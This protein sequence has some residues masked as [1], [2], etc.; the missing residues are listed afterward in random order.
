M[1]SDFILS[2]S[3]REH[4]A[5]SAPAGKP[6]PDEIATLTL[7]LRR[8]AEAP[9]EHKA[10]DHLSHAELTSLYGADPHDIRAVELFA[11]LHN[12]HIQKVHAGARTV[13]ISGH[14]S[15][16]AKAFGAD[17]QLRTVAGK[18]FQTHVGPLSVPAQLQACVVAVLGFDQRP[19][20]ATNHRVRPHAAAPSAYTPLQLASIYN[21]PKASGEG[22]TIA[23]IE[24]GGGYKDAD[25]QAYW[26]Q[27]GLSPVSVS[28]VSVDGA[29]NAPTGDPDGPDGEVLLDIQVAGAIAPSADIAVYFA[30]NT[31]EGFLDAINA[32]I[33]DTERKPSIISISWGS[34]ENEWTGQSKLAFN[35]AFHD[36]AL[37]GISVLA[38]AGDNGSSDGED[39]DKHV[40]FPAS[41]PWVLACGGTSLIAKNGTIRSETVWNDGTNGGSTGGGVSSF[42]SRPAYQAH[43][44][45]PS[46]PT[47]KSGRGVP[48]IAAVADP[49]TGYEVLI[50]GQSTVIGGTS[51]VAP[52]W[53]GLIALCNQELGKN[54]GWM[55]KTLYGTV[56][57]H[58]VLHD[59]VSGTNGA[60][61][62]KVGWDCCTGLGTPN[63]QAL[64]N[65]FKQNL[66]K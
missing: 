63:G 37:L 64:L 31:D 62:A 28:A 35:S 1:S 59:I 52:L 45:V 43:A 10:G 51:A 25:L 22:Q 7:L 15:D 61:N 53:S 56:A 2:G 38:A 47:G 14:R 17:L 5:N 27:L 29:E 9:E 19:V 46:A 18:T 58:K 36:A 40:D 21:F 66:T 48:D 34:G 50:D 26:H 32:A 12:F 54:L 65:V 49:D 3:H 39:T 13:V 23:I 24:L 42:F 30:P 41:S 55:H 4:P 6:A 60:Y 20:A 44:N 57:Q 33:H 8:K 16:L 11:A